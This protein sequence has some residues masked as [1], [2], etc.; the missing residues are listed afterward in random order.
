[1]LA[2][3]RQCWQSNFRPET[4]E[5]ACVRP[6]IAVFVGHPFLSRLPRIRFVAVRPS[7]GAGAVGRAMGVLSNGGCGVLSRGG[8]PC[9]KNARSAFPRE[10]VSFAAGPACGAMGSPGQVSQR[11]TNRETSRADPSRRIFRGERQDS[12]GAC[13]LAGAATVT[14]G[15]R[16][17]RLSRGL[18]CSDGADSGT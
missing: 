1:M 4:G 10:A 8:P 17:T 14:T 6:V 9:S 11:R 7:S 15:A 18:F 12:C 2:P 16:R 5:A 3:C 13:G